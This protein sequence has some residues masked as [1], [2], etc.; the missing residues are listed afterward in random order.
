MV[1]PAK[2]SGANYEVVLKVQVLFGDE[3]NVT[4]KTPLPPLYSQIIF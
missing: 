4:R 2:M 1:S 3:L